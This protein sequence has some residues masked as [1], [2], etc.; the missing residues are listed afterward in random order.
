MRIAVL[1]AL[2]GAVAFATA[3]GAQLDDRFDRAFAALRAGVAAK[4]PVQAEGAARLLAAL[5]AHA[6]GTA[7]PVAGWRG[8]EVPVS[9]RER[10]LG[11]GYLSV[12][13]DGGQAF[14][15][16][17]AFLAG[18][19]ARVAAFATAPGPFDLTVQDDDGVRRCAAAG[20][21]ARCDWVPAYTS[22]VAIALENRDRKRA[23]FF[24]MLK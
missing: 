5:G 20:G 6:V 21:S 4:A 13:L 15:L 8:R 17:Q 10:L 11:P 18:Q 19:R 9:Y 7:D 2:G 12:A 3:V 22:R 24:V 1:L 16:E 23:T 14:R